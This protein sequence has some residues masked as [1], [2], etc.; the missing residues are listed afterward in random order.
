MNQDSRS[1]SES[2]SHSDSHSTSTSETPN[3]PGGGG[4][5]GGGGGDTPRSPSTPPA[6]VVNIVDEEV[7]LAVFEEEEDELI[8][9]SENDVPLSALPKTGDSS[10]ST[11]SLLGLMAISFLGV[12]GIRRKQK[13]E[14]AD[15]RS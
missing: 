10:L 9:I 6:E 7:P 15:K 5:D 3:T 13:E 14:D 2:T 1:T 11:K 4:N 12:V 8:E